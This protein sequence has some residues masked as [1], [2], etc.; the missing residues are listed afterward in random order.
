[1]QPKNTMSREL[2]DTLTEHGWAQN[3]AAREKVA[4]LLDDKG[5]TEPQLRKRLIYLGRAENLLVVLNP[6]RKKQ[7]TG[8][9]NTMTPRD[10][11]EIDRIYIIT[12]VQIDGIEPIAVARQMGWTVAA[13]HAACGQPVAEEVA[14]GG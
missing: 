11:R 8:E 9:R 6:K 10:H 5:V 3:P 13:V 7:N 14:N 12:R 1:M 2:Y 4:Q